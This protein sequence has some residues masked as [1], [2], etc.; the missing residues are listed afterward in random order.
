MKVSNTFKRQDGTMVKLV[1]ED[2]RG[3]F[4]LKPSCYDI[5][6]YV[7]VTREG[8]PLEVVQQDKMMTVV[9]AAEVIKTGL[10]LLNIA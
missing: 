4:R 6:Y 10:K 5:G 9:S 1:A 7:L 8:C 2:F 3:P